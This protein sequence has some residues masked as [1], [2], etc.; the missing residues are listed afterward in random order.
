MRYLS[1][2]RVLNRVRAVAGGESDQAGA[3]EIDAII[4]NEIRILIGI[5]AAGAKPDLPLLFVDPLDPADDEVSLGDLVF[6][7]PFLGIDQIQMPPA[8]ALARR[9]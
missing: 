6:D 8:V 1:I 7:G 2:G 3:V 4:V 5:A 9:R